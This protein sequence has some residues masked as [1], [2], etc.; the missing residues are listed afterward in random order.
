M[1]GIT[2]HAVETVVRLGR[3]MIS[4]EILNMMKRKEEVGH[5]L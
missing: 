4:N 3:D 5:H 2:I 1:H